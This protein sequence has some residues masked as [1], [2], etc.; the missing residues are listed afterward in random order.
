MCVI[1]NIN[2]I[3]V[4]C[5]SSFSLL[6]FVTPIDARIHVRYGGNVEHHG[7]RNI[8]DEHD[9]KHIHEM[10]SA[11]TMKITTTTIMTTKTQT[12]AVANRC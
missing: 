3:G 1:V 12:D 2:T 7:T 8:H 10:T 4:V 11:A 6:R 9:D 5:V